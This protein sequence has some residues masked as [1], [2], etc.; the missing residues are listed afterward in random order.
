MR[1]KYIQGFLESKLESNYNATLG[2][3]SSDWRKNTYA[4]KKLQA[5][6]LDGLCGFLCSL[7]STCDRFVVDGPNC[8]MGNMATTN[9]SVT[10]TIDNAWKSYSKLI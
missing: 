5:A 3:S 6:N 8:H 4:T 1:A 7:T 2:R 9:G 10:A